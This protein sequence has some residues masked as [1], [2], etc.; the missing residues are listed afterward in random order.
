MPYS[1]ET[2][3]G[4]LH[5]DVT[6]LI[7]H[8][9]LLSRQEHHLAR[10]AVFSHLHRTFNEAHLGYFAVAVHVEVKHSAQYL[11]VNISSRHHK[12]LDL[13]FRHFE[14]SLS[15]KLHPAHISVESL[16][17]SERRAGVEPHFR[18][19]AQRHLTRRIERSL[20][21]DK[22]GC[23]EM[24]YSSAEIPHARTHDKKNEHR[25]RI[26]HHAPHTY[27]TCTHTVYL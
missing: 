27:P 8:A 4:V 26:A 10:R 17:I 14:I 2:H 23:V 20:C 25:C 1:V 6:R 12:R 13:V 19:I 18:T 16:W 21:H 9:C 11:H 24:S 7:I 5:N 15:V 22:F 3:V